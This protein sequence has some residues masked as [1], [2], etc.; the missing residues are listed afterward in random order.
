MVDD[1]SILKLE[2]LRDDLGNLKS[3]IRKR[4]AAATSQVT[5]ADIKRQSARLA[6]MWLADFMGRRGLVSLI[7]ENYA[8]DLNVSFNRLLTFSERASQRSSYEREIN[9]VLKEFTSKLIIPLK[10]Q[11][12]FEQGGNGAD[13]PAPVAPEQRGNFVA[14][15]FVGHSFDTADQRI[16]NLVTGTLNSLGIAVVTGRKPRAEKISDKVKQLIDEQFIFVGLFTRRAKLEGGMGWTTSPWVIDEKAYAIAKAKVIV[17][18]I[19]EGIDSI[20]GLQGDL[21][22]LSFSRRK[23]HDLMLGLLALFNVRSVGMA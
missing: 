12:A 17:L 20:G 4:Y 3:D 9:A 16:V 11:R 2:R 14:T 15:S 19:E 13:A 21:E 23:L 5:A 8:A 22:Y 6:E 10:R 7:D 1:Q 18:L